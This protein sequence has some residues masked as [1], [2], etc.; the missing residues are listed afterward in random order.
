M[1]SSDI[2]HSVPLLVLMLIMAF[3][4][5]KGLRTGRVRPGAIP[6]SRVE[7]P[8]EFWSY[9]AFAAGALAILAWLLAGT[10][11]GRESWRALPLLLLYGLGVPAAFRLVRGVQTGSARFGKSTF[12]R[13]EAPR[14]YRAAL[15]FHFLV[16]A[17]AVGIALGWKPS[18]PLM[19]GST[20]RQVVEPVV[21]SVRDRLGPDSSPFFSNVRVDG[22]SGLV[23]G[24]VSRRG[25]KRRFFGR[26]V[27]RTG[28]VRLEGESSGF[29]RAHRR[30]CSARGT[31]PQ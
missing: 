17:L 24:E 26:A 2:I 10:L 12:G 27:Q 5:V 11:Q 19:G 4:L 1:R 25:Q 28:Q 16:A 7:Q 20:Y 15:L 8:I 23:C 3:Q 30:A 13:R 6:Y 14:G 31:V 22:R 29:D 9:F 18:R 21:Q